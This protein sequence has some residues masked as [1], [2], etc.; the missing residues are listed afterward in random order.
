M[1]RLW[2]MMLRIRLIHVNTVTSGNKY[3]NIDYYNIVMH[4][5][6]IVITNC[7]LAKW[8]AFLL[9]VVIT[10]AMRCI[11]NPDCVALI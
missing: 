3:I 6:G 4:I 1:L 9:V 10:I 5:G 11:H 7:R 2:K 8:A